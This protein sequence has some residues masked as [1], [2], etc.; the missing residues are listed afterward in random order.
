MPFA[1]EELD[2]TNPYLNKSPADLLALV[3]DGVVCE[4]CGGKGNLWPEH[5]SRIAE[6]PTTIFDETG[7]PVARGETSAHL[8]DYR[9]KC[10]T[11][12]GKGRVPRNHQGGT[13]HGVDG[14]E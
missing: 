6:I 7:D 10:P 11:C 3:K 2:M 9:G 1:N 14:G 5:H 4:R 8:P 12:S 13:N